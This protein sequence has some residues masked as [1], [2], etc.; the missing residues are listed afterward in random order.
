MCTESSKC[1][2]NHV[3]VVFGKFTSLCCPTFHVMVQLLNPAE[4]NPQLVDK[5]NLTT[6]CFK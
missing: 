5:K 2:N 4:F 1:P 3:R 6:I